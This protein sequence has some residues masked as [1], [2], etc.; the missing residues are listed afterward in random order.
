MTHGEIKPISGG[1]VA[2]AMLEENR[3]LEG[4]RRFGPAAGAEDPLDQSRGCLAIPRGSDLQR[5]VLPLVSQK[6]TAARFSDGAFR[7]RLIEAAS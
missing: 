3:S 5:I 2:D 7:K 4:N 1:I 6:E